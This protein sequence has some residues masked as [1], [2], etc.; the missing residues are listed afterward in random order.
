MPRIAY[1]FTTFPKL[2]EQFFLREVLALQQQGVAIELYS[3]IGGQSESEAGPV[4]EMTLRAWFC[5]IPELIYWWIVK[6]SA[7]WRMGRLL[8]ARYGSWTNLGENLLG[9]AFA[10][11]FARFFRARA[12]D[13]VHATWATAPGMAAYG[14][15]LLIGQRYTL[16]AHAYD[17]FRDGGDAFL[18]EKLSGAS[19]LRSST[20]STSDALKRCLG[21]ESQAKVHCVRRGLAHLPAYRMPRSRS[22]CD[23][24]RV[25]SVGRLIE[26]KGYLHQLKLYAIW[27]AQGVPFHATIIGEGPLRQQLEAAIARLGLRAHV[28]LLGE[29]DYAAVERL[30]RDA[31]LF[32]FTG[33]VAASGDRDG[34]PN[35]I[36]EAMSYSVPVFSTDVSGTTEA[37]CEGATGYIIDLEDL[38]GA[39][40]KILSRML[41]HAELCTVTGNAYRWVQTEFNVC[42]NMKQLRQALWGQEASAMAESGL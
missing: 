22:D 14:L 3:M 29:Q 8:C 21:G 2:S 27:M 16:E 19:A 15:R 28:D 4:T 5:V 42:N 17:V 24:L 32:L 20:A 25:L 18:A 31:D 6:P 10:L 36:A 23:A 7:L 35:V 12:Y 26:K 39:A 11:R 9:A 1:L 33:M 38:P 41:S 40:A 37:V 30:Y 13:A 34:L